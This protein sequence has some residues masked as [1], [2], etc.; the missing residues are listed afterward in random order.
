VGKAQHAHPI[1]EGMKM[2]KIT[3]ML[4]GMV[5][6]PLWAEVIPFPPEVPLD[7]ISFQVSA[8]QWVTT[9]TALLSV[10]INATLTNS[11]LVKT[12]SEIMETLSKIAEGEWHLTQFDRSQ[13]S[14]GLEKLYVQAQIRVDQSNLTNIYK[15]AK[16][17]SKPGANYE[18]ASIEFKPSLEET[19]AIQAQLREVLYQK[20]NDELARM[21]KVYGSQHYSINNLI[22]MDGEAPPVY[23][24]AKMQAQETNYTAMGAAAPNGGSL[25]VSN[26]LTLTA[27]VQAA[28]NRQQSGN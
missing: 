12:R 10:S 8:K 26:E 7:K 9:K 28:S 2:K 1:G 15:I 5:S 22:F 21:N 23:P 14:S 17:I 18:I 19:Q 3:G 16:D 4:I 11:D 6:L 25:A 13:D 20:A 27:V 24:M